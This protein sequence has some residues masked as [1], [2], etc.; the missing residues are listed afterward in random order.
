M[1]RSA[2]VLS[3]QQRTALETPRYTLIPIVR[4]HQKTKSWGTLHMPANFK[5]YRKVLSWA[6][7]ATQYAFDHSL[8]RL[9]ACSSDKPC[10]LRVCP[11]CTQAKAVRDAAILGTLGFGDD[12]TTVF[13]LVIEDI[14]EQEFHTAIRTGNWQHHH[15]AADAR[16][17]NKRFAASLLH[18]IGKVPCVL[19]PDVEWDPLKAA[20]SLHYHGLIFERDRAALNSLRKHRAVPHSSP[21][22]SLWRY[23][24][25]GSKI[26]LVRNKHLVGFRQELEGLPDR[27]RVT[28]DQRILHAN[29]SLI[30]WAAADPYPLYLNLSKAV[31]GSLRSRRDIPVHC[32]WRT[33]NRRPA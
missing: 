29:R 19:L 31:T 33:M 5:E 30:L 26:P 27:D 28:A 14:P 23:V 6:R 25:Y 9:A 2:L 11:C 8:D 1:T 15:N 20:F 17:M 10:G 32:S 4:D 24:R 16:D 12:A 21:L 22:Q 3:P 18:H 13:T 7:G